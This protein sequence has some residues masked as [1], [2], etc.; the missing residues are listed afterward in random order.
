[1]MSTINDISD[2][3]VSTAISKDIA[4]WMGMTAVVALQLGAY[5]KRSRNI[6]EP[7]N[8]AVIGLPRSGKTTLITSMFQAIFYQ[9]FL[10]DRVILRGAETIDRVNQNIE[11]IKLG[12]ALGPTP[13]QDM[14]AFR[15]DISVRNWLFNKI[16]RTA[17][18]DF[19]GEY[20]D[21]LSGE[22]TTKTLRGTTFFKWVMEADAYIFVF[23]VAAYM[24][25]SKAYLARIE[26]EFRSMWQHILEYHVEGK[27]S[28]RNKKVA[29]VANKCD[30]WKRSVENV[31]A[32]KSDTRDTAPDVWALGFGDKIPEITEL[33]I[34][35]A[36]KLERNANI[37]FGEVIEYFTKQSRFVRVIPVSSFARFD[38]Q[39]FGVMALAKFILP[40]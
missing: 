33:T 27:K 34:G 18:G 26:S 29:L 22:E 11:T 35:D 39:P 20:S 23:D 10:A 21:K 31:S 14:F 2:F 3:L 30:M 15:I 17:I 1:M 25:D 9:K 7:F 37:A 36:D 38:S 28:I 24:L 4:I 16:F 8:V 32:V 6:T 5:I 13:E 40:G 19:A 12:M